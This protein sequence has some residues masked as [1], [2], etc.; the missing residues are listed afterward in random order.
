M[1]LNLACV[2]TSMLFCSSVAHAAAIL[3]G[4]NGGHQS[5]DGAP[6]SVNNGSVV[7]ID[8]AT[9]AVML[10]GHPAGVTRLSGIVFA[11]P[12]LLYGSTLGA[13]GFPDFPPQPNVSHLIQIDPQSGR[14]ISDIGPVTD[15]V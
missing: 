13:G 5:L 2:F 1:R 9:G 11:G 12:D 15:G 10:V 14:L 6:L 3:Y 7:T 4:G 8:E